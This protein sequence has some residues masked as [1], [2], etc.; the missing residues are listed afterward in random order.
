ME[1]FDGCA[2]LR[3]RSG[4]LDEQELLREMDREGISQ[5]AVAAS[6]RFIAV[7]NDE[8][9]RLLLEAAR[10]SGGRLHA[11]ASA[12]P[13]YGERAAESLRR[14]FGE[15][16]VGLY[17]NPARQGFQL[18]ESVVDQL[19]E[20]CEKS[21]RSV[22]SYTGTPVCA[23]PFQLAEL[24]RRHPAV[25]FVMGHAA[26]S[27]FSG[28]DVVP[29][30]EQAPNVLVDTSCTIWSIVAGALDAL[31]ESRIVFCSAFPKSR[32]S[33]ELAKLRRMGWNDERWRRIGLTNART[34]WR[35][36]G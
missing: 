31:G 3:E 1:I 36:E 15:G 6:D 18:S 25:S 17:L 21:G 28:Y 14:A 11:L 12:N 24:A 16:C 32:A 22:Y 33:V 20:V 10:R 9:N 13:W 19:I 30:A 2:R 35:V 8:G 29:A 23:M 4:R 7:D 34:L 27:D 5:A 26:W